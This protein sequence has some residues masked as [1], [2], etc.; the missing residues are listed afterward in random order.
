M[1]GDVPGTRLERVG[2]ANAGW[3]A[4]GARDAPEGLPGRGKGHSRE[5]AVPRRPDR[6]NAATVPFRPKA[7]ARQLGEA[8]E[9][10]DKSWGS[11]VV[12]LGPHRC[13]GPDCQVT[14]A[15]LSSPAAPASRGGRRP[16]KAV[17]RGS[18]PRLGPSFQHTFP[19]SRPLTGP[20]DARGSASEEHSTRVACAT[21]TSPTHSSSTESESSSAELDPAFNPLA[22]QRPTHF[23]GRDAREGAWQRRGA[24]GAA[25]GGMGQPRD[26][27]RAAG[28]ATVRQ[29]A[30]P[31][32]SPSRV[33][34]DAG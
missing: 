28:A 31:G 33:R 30:F 24:P 32:R 12:E 19:P 17:R 7:L 9:Q 27:R 25:P 5:K 3:V 26:S 6:P 22:A 15:D 16:A 29:R 11:I 20:L 23:A 34:R 2:R 21:N 14:F 1:P 10:P 4:R 13:R 18:T 8:Q